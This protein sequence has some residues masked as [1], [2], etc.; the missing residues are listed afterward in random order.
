MIAEMDSPCVW[1]SAR[2]RRQYR[3]GQGLPWTNYYTVRMTRM[4]ETASRG[5]TLEGDDESLFRSSSH[6]SNLGVQ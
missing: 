5:G 4:T 2:L 6:G 3:L 1:S